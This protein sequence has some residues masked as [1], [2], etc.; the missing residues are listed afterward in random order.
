MRWLRLAL[1][2][3]LGTPMLGAQELRG[4]VTQAPSVPAPG[5]IVEATD[6]ATGARVVSTLTDA[7]GFFILRL[8]ADVE[9]TV[10]GLRIGQRPSLFGT[11]RL[12][13]G[14]VRTE[15]F[16]LSGAAIVLGRIDVVSQSVCGAMRDTGQVV[17]TLYDEARKALRAT[18]LTTTQGRLTAAWVLS[19]QL[20]SLRAEP[21]GERRQQTFRATTDRPFVSL[22][23]DSLARVGYLQVRE[24]EYTYFAPD[25]EVLLSERFV[26]D[27]CFQAV[28]WRGDSR[29]WVGVGFRPARSARGVVGIEGTLWLE[30]GSSELRRLDYK[31]VNLPRDV[32]GATADGT[33]EFL[34]LPSGAWLVQRW[35]I[36]MPKPTEY[37][38]P[39]FRFGRQV[40][41]T[42][43]VRL[44]SLE[45]A[46]GEVREIRA[47]ERLVY[48]ADA[49]GNVREV[50]RSPAVVASLCAAPPG[51]RDGVLYGSVRD[52]SD[53]LL[54]DVALILEWLDDTRWLADWQRTYEERRAVAR[55]GADGFWFVC[56][57]PRG[58]TV[59]VTASLT[60]V[61]PSGASM[62]LLPDQLG[63]EVPLTIGTS[64]AVGRWSVRGQVIDSLLGGGAWREAA[65]AVL[66]G[67]QVGFSDSL[68]RFRIDSLPVGEHELIATDELMSFYHI[69]PAA[70]RVRVSAT[71]VSEPVLLWRPSLEALFAERCGR[72]PAAGEGLLIGEVRDLGSVRRAG[73]AVSATWARTLITAERT[74]RDERRVDA[75]TNDAGQFVLCGVPREGEA[76]K[77]G[78]I[79]VY[80]SGEVLLSA[81]SATHSSGGIG[82]RLD[83]APIRRRDLIVGG[84]RN[85]QRLAGRVLDNIGRPI[86]EAT[87]VIGD[88][89]GP[90]ART[91]SLGR[92]TIDSVAVRSTALTVR[93]LRFAPLTTTLDPVGGRLSVGEIRLDP[94]A[95]VLDARVTTA[96][97]GAGSQAWRAQFEER[98]RTYA[99]G[100]FLD[101]AALARQVVVTPQFL[102]RHIPKARHSIY[103]GGGGARGGQIAIGKSKIGFEVDSGMQGMTLCF[104][105][106]FI[107]GSDFGVPTA[108]EEERFLREAKRVEAY[109][110]SL[111]PP[112]YNDFDGC[113]VILIWTR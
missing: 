70:S 31:Y 100:T 109:K 103:S 71:G 55:T 15:Q 87:V 69:P 102:I 7:R 4:T 107:D 67:P 1:C 83:G 52:S 30:R 5:V 11:Y 63:A 43:V 113:G 95:Q 6:P 18:Q 81:T 16:S 37:E 93:A 20:T 47:G 97:A 53:N 94:A 2:V 65:V 62:R 56:G 60:G 89:S 41:T 22:S 77:T 54:S 50:T 111:A 78:A 26:L 80:A 104:P 14:E 85:R 23:S 79:A 91:D 29:D 12:A 10:R 3:L 46:G 59:R 38:E 44:R 73:I 74:E 32:S 96:N 108:D 76:S 88:A 17:A 13:A 92:W 39:V 33:V 110:A 35:Q 49:T 27:H 112:Q 58:A 105:R 25:A 68:G 34:R 21:L 64:P 61:R 84:A 24:G 48:V 19:N 9:V 90:S 86:P 101:D 66:G 98:K 72:A 106:W 28:P 75:T 36:R 57:V 45:V 51:P 8:P 82:V 99:F 42:K 40:G